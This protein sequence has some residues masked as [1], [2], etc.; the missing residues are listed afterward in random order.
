MRLKICLLSASALI[1]GA[2]A[3]ATTNL[4]GKNPVAPLGGWTRSV[5][6]AN[7]RAAQSPCWMTS[8]EPSICDTPS[9]VEPTDIGSK[10]LRSAVLTN[11]DGQQQVL[12]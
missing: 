12:G 9:G 10:T 5:T 11:A 8:D 7:H 4:H 1:G 6:S 3:F 2:A